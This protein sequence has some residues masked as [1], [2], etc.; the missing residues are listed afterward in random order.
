MGE[1]TMSRPHPA[2]AG[3]VTLLPKYGPWDYEEWQRVWCATMDLVY[4]GR[5]A[6]SGP[7][8]TAASKEPSVEPYK[9]ER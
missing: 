9:E 3:L 1:A 7:E 6:A 5:E 2:L 8:A 4:G